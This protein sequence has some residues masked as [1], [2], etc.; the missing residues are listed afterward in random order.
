MEWVNA[1]SLPL[2]QHRCLPCSRLRVS[3][4]FQ[5]GEAA[6]CVGQAVLDPS[7][8]AEDETSS[9]HRVLGRQWFIILRH[10]NE[11]YMPH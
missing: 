3:V 4:E 6:E 8:P 1:R 2:K 11:D 10:A 7:L 5:S 9:R